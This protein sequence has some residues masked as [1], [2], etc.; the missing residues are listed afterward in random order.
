M[1]QND[2]YRLIRTI[3]NC[4]KIKDEDTFYSVDD[5][6]VLL[7]EYSNTENSSLNFVCPKDENGDFILVEITEEG[8]E[9]TKISNNG[10]KYDIIDLS[11]EDNFFQEST[12]LDLGFTY[13][14]YCSIRMDFL[15]Y[16]NG[17]LDGMTIFI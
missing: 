17:F 11:T 14:E 5:N 16:Y 12:V 3:K 10:S 2:V 15:K 8:T 4:E 13:D 6:R 7:F 9:F 1:T